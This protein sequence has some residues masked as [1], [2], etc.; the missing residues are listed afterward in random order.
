MLDYFLIIFWKANNFYIYNTIKEKIEK[1]NTFHALLLEYYYFNKM[2]FKKPTSIQ[3]KHYFQPKQ[4]YQVYMVDFETGDVLMTSKVFD[5]Y[6][7]SSSFIQEVRSNTNNKK[8][9]FNISYLTNYEET[10]TAPFFEE[11]P[12]TFLSESRYDFAL[13]KPV[14]YERK[15]TTPS[16]R[17][18]SN[19]KA[20]GCKKNRN[21]RKTRNTESFNLDSMASHFKRMKVA[22]SSKSSKH[23]TE[24]DEAP[25]NV[26][27]KSLNT[28]GDESGNLTLQ[29]NS[30]DDTK[31]D[32]ML[33][34]LDM[35]NSDED[36]P[37][38]HD[39]VLN[40][41]G[42]GYLLHSYRD[43]PDFG[44]KYYHNAWWMP[45]CE[46]WFLMKQYKDYFIENGA[47]LE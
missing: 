13:N 41:Y 37:L 46:A 47:V 20:S 28:Y 42:K 22:N 38:F 18:H 45:K 4:Y 35:D 5:S 17:C 8:Y 16:T 25:W 27:D 31:L 23:N 21:G 26:V 43:H 7:E 12:R 9:F 34:N 33:Q 1:K 24:E 39:M 44:T 2:A 3:N 11:H 14:G 36:K 32:Q 6:M 40:K 15:S 29:V 10:D 30:S 19:K